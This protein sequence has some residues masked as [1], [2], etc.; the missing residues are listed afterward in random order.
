VLAET[1]KARAPSDDLPRVGGRRSS[2]GTASAEPGPRPLP[3]WFVA[4]LVAAVVW[5]ATAGA[6][7][8]ELLAHGWYNAYQVGAAATLAC[9]FSV[10]AVIHGLGRRPHADHAAA[11]AA[12]AIFVAFFAFA[13]AFHSEHLLSDRDPAL[14]ITTGR[15]IARTHELRPKTH[16]GAYAS[17][18]FGNP[19]GR[20]APNF[21]PML[22]VLLA[23]GWS[24]GGDLGLLL[25]GPL[26]GAL[27]VLACYALASRVLGTRWALLA[28]ILLIIEPLQVWFARDA[29][30]E[31][32]VQVVV[33]GGLWLFLEARDRHRW[34]IAVLSGLVL[35]TSALARVDALAILTGALAV[36][37]AAWLVCDRDATPTRARRVVLGFGC[38][39]VAGTFLATHLS[40]QVAPGYVRA[41]GTE[42]RQLVDMFRVAIAA[43]IL[44][45]VAHRT[46]PG[47]GRWLA[48]RRYLFAAAVAAAAAVSLWAYVWRP[49]PVRDLPVFTSSAQ[50]TARLRTVWA[51][52]HYSWSLHW[53]SA[54]FGLPAIM[55][56]F[57][58]FVILASRA[59]RGNGA[60]ATV[61]LVVVPVAVL[62]IARPSITPDQPWAMRRYLPVVIPGIVIAIVAALQTGWRATRSLRAGIVASVAA[63][64]G[65]VGVALLVVVPTAAAAVPFARARAQHGSLAVVHDICE[66]V[67]RDGAVLVYGGGFIHIELP[68]AVLVFCGVP[69]A[70]SATVDLVKLAQQWRTFG[71]SLFVATDSPAVVQQRAPGSKVVGHWVIRDDHEPEK[72][73]ERSPRRSKPV[74]L[75]VWLLEI[76]AGG[77]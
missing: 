28:P 2:T 21:F 68:P 22:P 60:A 72:A 12:V 77:K 25:V 59:R 62:Y 1:G 69:T 49:D 71:R 61:F 38:V 34:G 20:Y 39:L 66:G 42:Y 57:V 10:V 19:D 18:E 45:I 46:R 17:P 33:V 43:A 67:G 58:G 7:G 29:Y 44:V 35:T 40:E 73:F 8:I 15:S 52:W 32:V 13:G 55:I 54:Y 27:G 56:A 23:M 3:T 47:L 48:S 4:G 26:L 70:R 64:A 50:V 53:F 5:C 31:L 30:S 76:P 75:E 37:T 11:L 14:Y 6:V 51:N 74:P 65:V 63:G 36:A 41:L 24:V 9:V 16:L